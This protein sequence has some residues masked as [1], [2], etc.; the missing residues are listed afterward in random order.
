MRRDGSCASQ[1]FQHYLTKLHFEVL[2]N[3]ADED[4]FPLETFYLRGNVI[5]LYTRLRRSLKADSTGA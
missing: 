2:L 5:R 3:L 1:V 4:Y